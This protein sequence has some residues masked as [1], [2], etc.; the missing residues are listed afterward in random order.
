MLSSFMQNVIILNIAMLRVI[1]LF[2][3]AALGKVTKL[4]GHT[5]LSFLS[6]N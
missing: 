4:F 2:Y 1:L 5:L 3:Q 6:Q